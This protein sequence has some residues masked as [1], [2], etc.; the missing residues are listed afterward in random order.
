M[1]GLDLDQNWPVDACSAW[2]LRV[3]QAVRT[4]LQKLFKDFQ[5]ADVT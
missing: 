3:L 1:N 4:V 2:L 5:E